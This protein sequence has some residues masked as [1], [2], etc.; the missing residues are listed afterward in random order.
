MTVTFSAISGE[1]HG[2][3]ANILSSLQ[4]TLSHQFN[5]N[6]KSLLFW[7]GIAMAVIVVSLKLLLGLNNLSERY[8][9]AYLPCLK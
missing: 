8:N 2:F 9:R 7:E 5:N 6:Q 3:T 1:L 4:I